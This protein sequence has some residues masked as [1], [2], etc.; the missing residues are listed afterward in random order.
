MK[1]KRQ[2]FIFCVLLKLRCNVLLLDE[3]TRNLSPLSSP[4]IIELL[5]NFTGCIICVTHDRLLMERLHAM[6]YEI[7]DQRLLLCEDRCSE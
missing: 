1:G 4:L 7:K 5:D 3:P 6:H 2:S